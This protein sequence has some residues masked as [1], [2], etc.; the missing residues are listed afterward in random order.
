VCLGTAGMGGGV[1]VGLTTS[2]GTTASEL[3]EV[4]MPYTMTKV[5][6]RLRERG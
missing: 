6:K 1:R 3:G 4:P 2:K 5:P